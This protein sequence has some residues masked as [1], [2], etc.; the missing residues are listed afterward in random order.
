[1][2]DSKDDSYYSA[3]AQKEHKTRR[4]TI[5]TMAKQYDSSKFSASHFVNCTPHPM[6]LYAGLN[7]AKDGKEPQLVIPVSAYNARLVEEKPQQGNVDPEFADTYPHSSPPRY[8]GVEGL[9]SKDVSEAKVLVVSMLVGEFLA[10]DAE[11]TR[12]AYGAKH[13]VGP[14]SGPAGC[15]RDQQGGI[16]GTTGFVVYL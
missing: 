16:K 14:N 6:S 5:K 15:V 1:M 9:P 10:R 11:K 2:N 12:A 3:C 13:V 4:N 7:D 8:V